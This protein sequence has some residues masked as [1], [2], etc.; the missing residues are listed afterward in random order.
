MG[1]GER[2][3]ARRLESAAIVGHVMPTDGLG[4][5]GQALLA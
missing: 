2:K 3:T 1:V 5:I 4:I